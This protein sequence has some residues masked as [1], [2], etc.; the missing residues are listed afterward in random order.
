[1]KILLTIL[2]SFMALIDTASS[3]PNGERLYVN[4]KV[5]TADYARPYAEAVAIRDGRVV[6]VGSRLEASAALGADAEIVDLRGRFLMPGLVDSHC[7]AVIGGLDLISAD[8]EDRA[9]SV[10]ELAAF[11][12]EAR[13]SGRGMFGNVLRITG[14]PLAMWT[15]VD[16]LSEHFDADA[17]ASQ[18]VALFGMDGHTAWVNTAMRSLAGID[19]MLVAVQ[20]PETRALFGV[21]PGGEP[22]GLLAEAA[23]EHVTSVIPDPDATRMLEA[24][25]YAVRYLHSSG[26]TAWL[27]PAADDA[28]LEAYREMS[29]TGELR[30][31]VVAL[32][33]VDMMKGNEDEQLAAALR[34]REAFADVT[35]VRVGGIKV[36]AD[37]VA[38]YPT[39]TAHMSRPYRNSGRNGELLF[40]PQRFAQIATAAD[41]AG[42]I[43]HV[44]AIGDQAVT[45]ALDGIEVARRTNGDSGVLHSITHLQ[46]V[47]P[48]DMPRFR[49]LGVLASFQLYWARGSNT[50]IDL[51][52]PYVEPS[53]YRWQYPARSM[54]D[55]GVT[56]AGGS[57]WNVSTANVFHAIYRAE[58]R[59]GP[60]GV[61]DPGQ[62]MPRIAMLYAYT[63]E[64]ARLLGE[65]GRI[66]SIA[67]GKLADFVVLD[68]D[69]LTVTS[70]EA[71]DTNVLWT[72]VGGETVFG[73]A[74][75]D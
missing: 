62:R 55:A 21:G 3:A 41:R 16:A 57:D 67:P 13:G 49:D 19:R 34:H 51:V 69:V 68:R 31:R 71:R 45:E 47:R 56:I 44:H 60:R 61:L 18:P 28:S 12:A 72:I 59:N 74:P 17:Y 2:I 73:A 40:D 48:E 35:D 5:F 26:I 14:V 1:M 23:M 43:V 30:S 8:N 24:G 39:Q 22:N 32:P 64:A 37:G 25:R 66:G 75:P 20:D 70:D 65:D 15:R 10:E 42:M 9:Q 46:F 53:L 50:T 58:T 29:A 11:A 4:A 63:I 38:E 52:E 27:D 54:L 7:H 33:V 36:F 6:A